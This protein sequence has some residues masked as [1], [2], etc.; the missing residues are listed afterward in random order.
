M[1]VT[2]IESSSGSIVNVTITN[3]ENRLTIEEMERII[4]E[5]ERYRGYL[6]DYSEQQKPASCHH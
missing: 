3:D 2:G 5:A 6:Q 4:A 1:N